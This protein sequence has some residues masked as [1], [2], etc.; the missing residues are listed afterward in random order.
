MVC[1]DFNK[2]NLYE[3]VD[4]GLLSLLFWATA[5]GNRVDVTR[6]SLAE[7]KGLYNKWRKSV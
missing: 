2:N 6:P 3:T 1:V 7:N 4:F 5:F